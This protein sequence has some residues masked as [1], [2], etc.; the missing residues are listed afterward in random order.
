MYELKLKSNWEKGSCGSFPSSLEET[1][2]IVSI[3]GMTVNV[4]R[5]DSFI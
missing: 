1:V 4:A 5:V 2:A 3:V